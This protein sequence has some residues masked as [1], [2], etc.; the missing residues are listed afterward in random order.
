MNKKLNVLAFAFVIFAAMIGTV[1]ADPITVEDVNV[2][3]FNEDFVVLVTLNNADTT[4]GVH[5]ELSFV[6]DELGSTVTQDFIANDGGSEVASFD[7]RD[8]VDDF[9]DLERGETYILEVSNENSTESVAFQFG[10]GVESE[11][12]L[13][14]VIDEIELNSVDITNLDK[15]FVENGGVLDIRI[16]FDALET[17]DDAR[18]RASIDGYEHGIIDSSTDIFL[19]GSGNTYVKT[20]RLNLPA[21]M[22]SQKDYVLRITGANDLSG[23]LNKELTIFVGAQRHRVDVLDLVMTP[24]SGVEPG[25]NIIAN[26]RLKNRGQKDQD[27]VRVS[28]S[29]PELGISEAS[30]VSNLNRE[31][32]VTSDDML[33]FVPSN[34][35]AKQ[36]AVQV[37]LAYNDGYTE[38]IESYSL[39]VLAPKIVAEKN[40]LVS[41][42]NNIDLSAGQE[43][44]FEVVIANPNSESKPIS[45]VSNGNNWADVDVTP[46]LGFIKGDSSETF[47]VTVTPKSAIAGEKELSLLVKEGANTVSEITV[48]TYVEPN[49]GINWVNVLLAILLI[50]AI[51]VLLALVVA[52]AKRR[53]GNDEEDEVS[54]SEEYY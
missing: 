47:T 11:D 35:Q 54:S 5:T 23:L 9:S 28:V 24:S 16:K 14:I 33:L 7:L 32:V 2:Q 41:F 36:Y 30:Y 45:I 29:I 50:I 8:V 17:F 12:G 13:D 27:S 44:S 31:E 1:F 53:N 42:K 38:S 40:L 3:E 25:Q 4:S 20:L 22:D 48:Q 46:T 37:T 21:D 19:A 18:L 10:N 15:L 52:I 49:E 39:N 51:I 26:V 34:A 6:I 43:R